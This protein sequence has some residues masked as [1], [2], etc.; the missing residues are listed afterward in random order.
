MR[1]TRW[2]LLLAAACNSGDEV[3]PP[4]TRRVP[5]WWS[6]VTGWREYVGLPAS[7]NPA[8]QASQR[9]E[10]NLT[11]SVHV[12]G[13]ESLRRQHCAM[14]GSPEDSEAS[15]VLMREGENELSP[16]LLEGG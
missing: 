16:I 8:D 4:G 3:S 15:G 14:A 12:L 7:P 11:L 1:A 13:I 9:A 10:P 6:S 2:V 5:G